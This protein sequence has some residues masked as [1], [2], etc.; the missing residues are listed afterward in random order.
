VRIVQK[1]VKRSEDSGNIDF[2]IGASNTS[3]FWARQK[4]EELDAI[5]KGIKRS[6]K[7]HS[8]MIVRDKS[9]GRNSL[10][11]PIISGK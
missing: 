6:H 5:M 10:V 1:R 9:A 7:I 3:L 8:K 4:I 2:S 11:A